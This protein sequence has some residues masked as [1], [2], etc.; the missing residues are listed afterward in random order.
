MPPIETASPFR[1]YVALAR[2]GRWG[3]PSIVIGVA[4]TVALWIVTTVFVLFAASAIIGAWYVQSYGSISDRLQ[5]VFTGRAGTATLFVTLG[6][7]WGVVWAVLRIVHR[8]RLSSV[9][10]T[11]RRIDVRDGLKAVLAG[12]LAFGLSILV[13]PDSP[14]L[15]VA[16]SS[17]PLADWLVYLLPVAGLI[18]LQASAEEAVF[19]GY[20]MQLLANRF[21]S[22]LVWAAIPL[23]VFTIAHWDPEVQTHM[24]LAIFG[25]VS[26]FAVAATVLVVATGNLGAAMGYHVVNNLFAFLVFSPQGN[27]DEF[28]LYLYPA[29]SDPRWTV[30]EAALVVGMEV[31]SC[32]LVLLLLLHRRSPLRVG[33][34][35]EAGCAPVSVE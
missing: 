5:T 9:L 15:P 27:D 25:S 29:L 12:C 21:T 28:A 2:E 10:G 23:L 16:R 6:V 34:R 33:R 8:R 11:D 18:A 35:P 30:S 22:P 20:L 4:L 32:L 19:R 13:S 1:R 26:L 17:L 31:L 3:V 14:D 24:L 7:L